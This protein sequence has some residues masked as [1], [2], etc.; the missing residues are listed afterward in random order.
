MRRPAPA[1]IPLLSWPSRRTVAVIALSTIAAAVVWGVTSRASRSAASFGTTTPV[2]VAE[3]DLSPGSVIGSGDVAAH[4]WPLAFVPDDALEQDPTGLS[5]RAGISSGEA[6]IAERVSENGSGPVALI[7][8]GWRGVAIT[9]FDAPPPVEPGSTVD[10]IVTLDPAFESSGPGVL[11]TDA[12]VIHVSESG[13]TVTV[14]VPAEHVPAV[15]AAQMAG[16]LTLA[17]SG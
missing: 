13:S 2:W 17:L 4:D 9:P 1:R 5:V 16:A 15:A 10:L 14:A 8:S 11:V 3:R 6:V 7:P 12:I